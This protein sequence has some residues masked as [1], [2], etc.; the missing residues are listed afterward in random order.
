MGRSRINNLAFGTDWA[1][2]VPYACTNQESWCTYFCAINSDCPMSGTPFTISYKDGCVVVPPEVPPI[3]MEFL[4]DLHPYNEFPGWMMRFWM[5]EDWQPLDE[6]PLALSAEP[7][8]LR[9]RHLNLL[10]HP[11]SWSQMVE[12]LHTP[13]KEL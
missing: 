4:M 8:M 13:P 12:D 2:G 11:K 10:N 7:Y 9:R 5:V 6:Y 3:I 1:L